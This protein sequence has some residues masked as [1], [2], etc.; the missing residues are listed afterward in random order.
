M[1]TNNI[2]EFEKLFVTALLAEGVEIGGYALA[3]EVLKYY[4]NG[5]TYPSESDLERAHNS[6]CIR[7][8]KEI[9]ENYKS[10]KISLLTA[11]AAI[12]AF[13]PATQK[14]I[15]VELTP[16]YVEAEAAQREALES[17]L[18]R[19]RWEEARCLNGHLYA[20]WKR[21]RVPERDSIFCDT[22]S[23]GVPISL[24]LER[25]E[26]RDEWWLSG[27]IG[28]HEVSHPYYVKL[29]HLGTGR[30]NVSL[31][32][33]QHNG[34]LAVAVIVSHD[35]PD[36]HG[37]C[38]LPVATEITIRDGTVTYHPWREDIKHPNM[39][40]FQCGFKTRIGDVL[41]ASRT[42]HPG[43]LPKEARVTLP[44][45][46]TEEVEE[47]EPGVWIVPG[48]VGEVWFTHDDHL[49]VKV[50]RPEHL[51]GG[52]VWFIDAEEVPGRT[53]YAPDDWE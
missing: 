36:C 23:G 9:L 32:V 34:N 45:P 29:G 10:G 12:R 42:Y 19:M 27:T 40:R 5:W 49:P 43:P 13:E 46:M 44:R 22:V 11:I 4:L 14:T 17:L 24:V 18:S 53:Q 51:D 47:L 52:E 28:Q 8:Y 6:A 7:F 30:L 37:H 33:Y 39:G 50:S 2:K 25:R 1:R 26:K 48:D 35:R 31:D 20:L 41:L 3:A 21:T 15:Y 16:L 38:R